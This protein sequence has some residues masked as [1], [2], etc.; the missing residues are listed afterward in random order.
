MTPEEIERT[1]QQL[2]A[3]LRT[4]LPKLAWTRMPIGQEA[5]PTARGYVG[6]GEGWSLTVARFPSPWE[7]D[8]FGYDGMMGKFPTF[9]RMK[10]DLA[11]EIFAVAEKATP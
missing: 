2:A 9:S 11:E 3:E 4:V 6:I 7:P 8:V 5:H 1:Y 10:P